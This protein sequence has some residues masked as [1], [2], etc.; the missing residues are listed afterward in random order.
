MIHSFNAKTVTLSD[1]SFSM[2]GTYWCVCVWGGFSICRI[3]LMK[4]ILLATVDLVRPEGR[5][6]GKN[7]YK[8][9]GN[10]AT[11]TIKR[12]VAR[13]GR[14]CHPPIVQGHRCSN[15]NSDTWAPG[16]SG[17]VDA[18]KPT[19]EKGAAMS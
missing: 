2:A 5:A 13:P 18:P 9:Y 8:T 6:S 4:P 11:T 1:S 15:P 3:H 17:W 19:R 10:S 16:A 14:P 12:P 7:P